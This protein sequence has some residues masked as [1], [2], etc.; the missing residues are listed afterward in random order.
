VEYAGVQ[1]RPRWT[2]PPPFKWD[3][4]TFGEP[5]ALAPVAAN[6]PLVIEPGTHGYLWAINGKS[7][8]NTDD[9]RLTA[10][11]RNRLVFDNRAHMGHPVHLHRHSFELAFGVRKDV[12]MVPANTRLEADVIADTPGP[13]LFHCHQQLHMDFGFMALVRY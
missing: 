13:A 11:A 10:G 3:L 4:N 1:G 8:P 9:I 5:R 2:P 7:W 6:I 12:L